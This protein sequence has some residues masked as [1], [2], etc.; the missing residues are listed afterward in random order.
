MAPSIRTLARAGPTRLRHRWM[1]HLDHLHAATLR[2]YCVVPNCHCR[3]CHRFTS[4]WPTSFAFRR[5]AFAKS[6]IDTHTYAAANRQS[7]HAR[8]QMPV[9]FSTGMKSLSIFNC[10]RFRSFYLFSSNRR[11]V[12]ILGPPILLVLF[13]PTLIAPGS[14]MAPVPVANTSCK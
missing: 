2:I 5:F 7:T 6:A 12:N 8:R 13:P 9:I 14:V 3:F 11:G 10:F 1:N 4:D